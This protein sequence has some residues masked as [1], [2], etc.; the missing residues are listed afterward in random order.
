MP[1]HQQ[2]PP[3]IW[4]MPTGSMRTPRKA[5]HG[6]NWQASGCAAHTA[7]GSAGAACSLWGL[8]HRGVAWR[9]PG[10]ACVQVCGHCGCEGERD[11]VDRART[12]QQQAVLQVHATCS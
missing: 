1:P 8:S 7:A 11:A 6:A 9:S 3:R 5:L 10:L 4:A 2:V 12:M